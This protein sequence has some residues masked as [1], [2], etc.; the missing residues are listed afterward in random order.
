MIFQE[1]Q[2]SEE[3]KLI[4]IDMSQNT[5]SQ[6]D[7]IESLARKLSSRVDVADLTVN[8]GITF[9]DKES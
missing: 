4:P 9:P 5:R 1:P 7:L 6:F 3:Y 2:Q 8:S